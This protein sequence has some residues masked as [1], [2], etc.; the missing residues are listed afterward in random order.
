MNKNCII[1]GAN[2]G[3]GNQTALDIAIL[4]LINGNPF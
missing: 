2:D 3:I 1:T 4:G